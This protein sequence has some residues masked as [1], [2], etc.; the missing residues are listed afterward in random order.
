MKSL[1]YY[2]LSESDKH[3]IHELGKIFPK[4][5]DE[6]FDGLVEDIQLN[7]LIVPITLYENKVLDGK[8]RYRACL[9]TGVKPHFRELPKH[10]EPLNYIMSMNN[11][12]QT[13]NIP[14]K[15]EIIL[16]IEQ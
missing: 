6:E 5:S 1:F 10:I 2:T 12:R 7:G 8:E 9:I 15:C 16:K 4:M 14:T 11:C 13:F 3:E